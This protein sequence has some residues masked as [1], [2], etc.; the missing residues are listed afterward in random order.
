MGN[1]PIRRRPWKRPP[2]KK[3]RRNRRWNELNAIPALD[4]CVFIPAAA[5]CSSDD[6]SLRRLGMQELWDG[7]IDAEY[8][9]ASE[10]LLERIVGDIDVRGVTIAST[11]EGE[12]ALPCLRMGL[13]AVEEVET[14]ASYDPPNL[15]SREDLE[16]FQWLWLWQTWFPGFTG[17]QA[18]TIPGQSV[19]YGDSNHL[20][21]RV[22][23]SLGKKDHIVLL[24][25]YAVQGGFGGSTASVVYNHDLRGVFTV[26]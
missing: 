22:R 7:D 17:T 24:A 20:D 16:E 5:V 15:W 8:A 10:V 12:W 25:Q 13:L 1:G 11:P 4:P 18:S 19:Y 6:P 14:V 9:D 2:W 26:R 3:T 21:I 23:R